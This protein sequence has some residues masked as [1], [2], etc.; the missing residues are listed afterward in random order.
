[1][2][3]RRCLRS[4]QSFGRPPTGRSPLPKPHRD[5]VVVCPPAPAW[6][7]EWASL[8]AVGL[9]QASRAWPGAAVRR[10]ARGSRRTRRE[11]SWSSQ[12]RA[13][14]AL[15]SSSLARA[16]FL[17]S[18]ATSLTIHP[19]LALKSSPSSLAA[20]ACLSSASHTALGT[21]SLRSSYS[22][23]VCW[24][25][26]SPSLRFSRSAKASRASSRL[27]RAWRTRSS[28][29]LRCCS[30]WVR[31][32]LCRSIA[33]SSSSSFSAASS[34]ASDASSSWSIAA[35]SASTDGPLLPSFSASPLASPLRGW[36][37]CLA[38]REARWSSSR[39]R[40]R[41]SPSSSASSSWSIFALIAKCDGV[42]SFFL[43][44]FFLP[45]SSASPSRDSASNS[46]DSSL[47]ALP[48]L[49]LAEPLF[50]E[51]CEP[52]LALSEETC[53]TREEMEAEEPPDLPSLLFDLPPDL[54]FPRNASRVPC[55]SFPALPSFSSLAS[56]S[57]ASFSAF[58][59]RS[60]AMA[61]SRRLARP[62]R[63][64][65]R[66]SLSVSLRSRS[67]SAR[68]S[69]RSSMA[70]AMAPDSY[71][72]SPS[73]PSRASF[74]SHG[75]SWSSRR[76]S[77]RSPARRLAA[78]ATWSS[79]SVPPPP[80]VLLAVFCSELGDSAEFAA[81]EPVRK[82]VASRRDWAAL[83]RRRV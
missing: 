72:M 82:G 6:A 50:L 29:S 69:S 5:T 73:A 41:A 21:G 76:R 52:P 7:P 4:S 34:A 11:P 19:P 66:S 44:S 71:P 83:E 14:F 61:S 2:A 64:R 17:Y 43:P 1:M 74:C 70:S 23:S 80:V 16:R 59:S 46:M 51:T 27:R 56:A 9:S 79:H 15:A 37:A 57:A 32:S 18:A 13:C 39:P 78:R 75:S 68:L 49:P 58:S 3:Q 25:C 36:S 30:I 45:A 12:R 60:C 22:R 67:T 65:S 38:S 24:I 33:S 62:S 48:F 31:L 10:V 20:R 42:H 77:A 47:T 53:E 81:A 63:S 8:A 35:S 28:R 40:I 54:S 55:L 26:P